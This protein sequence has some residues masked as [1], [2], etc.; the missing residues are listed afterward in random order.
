MRGSFEA[1][2]VDQGKFF[3]GSGVRTSDSRGNRPESGDG[4]L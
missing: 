4:E 1:F 3:E 2:F